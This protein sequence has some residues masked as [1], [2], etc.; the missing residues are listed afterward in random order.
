M[1][2]LSS[3]DWL[4]RD[5][6]FHCDRCNKSVSYK[7]ADKSKVVWFQATKCSQQNDCP[8]LNSPTNTPNIPQP[9]RQVSDARI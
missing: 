1:E 5:G 9:V 3:P 6:C 2:N 7:F 4:F 8:N